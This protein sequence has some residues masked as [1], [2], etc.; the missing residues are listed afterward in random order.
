[1]LYR[2]QHKVHLISFRKLNVHVQV[3]DRSKD[4]QN[5]TISQSGCAQ[6]FEPMNITSSHMPRAYS[7][8]TLQNIIIC[9]PISYLL[10]VYVATTPT[11][12]Q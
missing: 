1:M 6:L 4:S 5:G 7:Q 12:M 10:K 8:I 11:R 3:C 9:L 2:G